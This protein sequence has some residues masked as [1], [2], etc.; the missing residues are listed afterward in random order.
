MESKWNRLENLL[1]KE[2][3][4]LLQ[5]KSVLIVGLGGVGGYVAE[6]LI[7]S[8]VYH[9]TIVDHDVVSL[10]NLNRQIIAL[11]STVGMKKVDLIQKRC[12]DIN[13]EATVFSY[14]LFVTDSNIDSLF[15]HHYDYVIDACD[16]ITTKQAL[17]KK[18]M[19][20]DI[21]L[22]SCM[23][24]ARKMDPTKLQIVDISKTNSDPLARIMRKFMRENF[25]N[26]KLWVLSSSEVAMK[27][28]SNVLASSIFVP[29]TAGLLIAHFVIDEFIK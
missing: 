13:K 9:L 29:A 21:P 5:N 19:S 7:R 3:L 2:N 25:P 18:C 11:E 15:E 17:I 10:S 8:G 6:A 26:Q 4:S 22:I 12:F 16:T 1:G 20:E 28:E 27:M 23:G 24:T 14:P